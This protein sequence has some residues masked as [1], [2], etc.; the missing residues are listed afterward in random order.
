MGAITPVPLVSEEQMELIRNRIVLP[1]LR[2]LQKRG[3]SFKGL[4]FPG[5]MLTKDGPRVIE[6]NARFGDPETQSYMRIL[7]SDLFDILY[8]CATGSL[9]DVKVHWSGEYACCV[10]LASRGYP[11]SSER[12]IPITLPADSKRVTVFHAGTANRA[13]ELVTNGGR[14]LGIT[15]TGETLEKALETAYHAISPHT[16]AGC[17]YRKDIG[18]S[19]A[20]VSCTPIG[21]HLSS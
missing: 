7:E 18:A 1:T 20:V 10:V 21:C 16:L 19:S 5:V 15:A 9:S 17:Q 12:G 2:G 11:A 8:A 14:V 6:F 13:G 4:L 3:R